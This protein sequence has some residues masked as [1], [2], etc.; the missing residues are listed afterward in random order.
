[1]QPHWVRTR[2]KTSR[3]F[4]ELIEKYF[5]MVEKMSLV[6]R[7]QLISKMETIFFKIF[8]K[9]FIGLI[10][11]EQSVMQRYVHVKQVLPLCTNCTIKKEGKMKMF[12]EIKN[13][14]VLKNIVSGLS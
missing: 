7:N 11:A 12:D 1:M 5:V 10:R 9:I 8:R 14:Q 2:K 4:Q 13:T 3:I 6:I